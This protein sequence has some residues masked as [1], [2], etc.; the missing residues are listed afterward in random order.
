[1]NGRTDVPGIPCPN[2]QERLV[3]TLEQILS[4]VP[5]ACRCGLKL[6]VDESQSQDT[7][8]DLRILRDHLRR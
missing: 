7:L 8:R 1:M 4:G 5:I 2:C 6:R 3:V